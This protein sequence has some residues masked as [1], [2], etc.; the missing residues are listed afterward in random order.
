ME[1]ADSL[2]LALL[3]KPNC[4]N[5]SSYSRFWNTAENKHKYL[6]S[7]SMTVSLYSNK[8]TRAVA[9][10]FSI[11]IALSLTC[12]CKLTWLFKLPAST[13]HCLRAP[14]GCRTLLCPPVRWVKSAREIKA[15]LGVAFNLWMGESVDKHS[16]CGKMA[17]LFP[18]GIKLW[19][20]T[21]SSGGECPYVLPS[22]SSLSSLL[23]SP[24]Y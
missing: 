20:P 21:W 7:I 4:L 11:H 19:L 24:F 6:L 15:P 14:S 23:I 16:P 13:F 2:P 8:Q 18:R 12:L 1:Q 17:P 10:V 22:F 3:G 5:T 9:I